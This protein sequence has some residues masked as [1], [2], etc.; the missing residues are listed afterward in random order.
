V[1]VERN[2]ADLVRAFREGDRE[3]F[4]L[5]IGRYRPRVVGLAIALLGDAASAEDIAQEATYHAFFDADHLRDPSRFGSWICGIAINLA[6]MARRRHRFVFSLDDLVGGLHLPRVE[7]QEEPS[8]EFVAE[9]TELRQRI[10]TALNLLPLEMRA[11]VWLH[12]VEGMTYQEVGAVTGIRPA[13]LKVLSHRARLQLRLAL[14]EEWQPRGK[15]KESKMAEVTIHDLRFQPTQIEDPKAERTAGGFGWMVVLKSKQD[16]R[17]LLIWIG[18]AEGEAMAMQLGGLEAPR[19]HTYTFMSRLIEGIGARVERVTITDLVNDAYFATA[20]VRTGNRNV[21]IDA[22]PSD[23]LNLALRTGASIYVTDAILEN[24]ASWHE[25]AT[26]EAG[27]DTSKGVDGMLE[28][29]MAKAEAAGRSLRPGVEV[30][31]EKLREADER[32]KAFVEAEEKRK[33]QST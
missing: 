30:I 14:A 16:N 15:M 18:P 29:M 4:A 25:K 21:E 33:Q 32:M 5:L 11:A 7:V 6:K 26:S 22:R 19:P 8:P 23:A 10:E 3:A 2:D 24:S 20:S 1:P 12:Y 17:G 13:T 31:Q 9:T 28:V 27:G